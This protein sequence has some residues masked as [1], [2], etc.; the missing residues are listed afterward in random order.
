MFAVTDTLQAL[1]AVAWALG[2]CV[3]EIDQVRADAAGIAADTQ[4]RARA[5]ARYHAQSEALADRLAR[6]A[7]DVADQQ[8]RVRALRAAAAAAGVT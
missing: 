4:W 3:R 2:G 8:E 5:V 1:D 7:D 6:L